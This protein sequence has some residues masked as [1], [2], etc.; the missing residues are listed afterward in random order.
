VDY[1]SKLDE[2]CQNIK[3]DNYY[4]HH[5]GLD[6]KDSGVKCLNLYSRNTT[7]NKP[8]VDLFTPVEP[9]T[10]EEMLFLKMSYPAATI[11]TPKE[12]WDKIQEII[13]DEVN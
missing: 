1:L 8:N 10:D 2:L 11:L 12:M 5:W 3:L 9:L 4:F 7:V 6:G 13:K